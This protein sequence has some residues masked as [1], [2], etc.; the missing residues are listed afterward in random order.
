MD[1]RAA[2]LGCALALAAA[3][4]AGD[5]KAQGAGG[6]PSKPVRLI[7][8]QDPGS[9]ADVSARAITPALS[10]ALGQQVVLD[11]RPGAGGALGVR[12]AAAAAPD[13]Y[14]LIA[15][16][17]IAMILPYVLK[18]PGY[19]AFRDFVPIGRYTLSHNVLV[20]PAAL[21]AN[22]VKE[23][24]AL[25]KSKPG[26]LNLGTAGIGSISHLSGALFN[27]LAG[28]DAVVVPYKGGG[29]AITALIANET[30]YYVAPIAAVLGQIKTGRVKALAVGGDTRAIQLPDVPTIAEAGIPAYRNFSWAGL[31]APAG[32][33]APVVGRLMEKLAAIMAL[34]AVREQLLKTGSEP[35]L[36]LGAEFGRFMREDFER[37]GIAARSAKL[38]PE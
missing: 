26:Q 13:G 16:S 35:S 3:V 15:M 38:Q 17:S 5:A 14:A 12:A 32:T 36:L 20:V 34:P 37:T 11:Y 19:D 31:L 24:V 21:P 33:P 30:Q 10:E 18:D 9:A 6:Y 4:S 7:I 1:T 25:A 28:I 29:A 23:L 2:A 8:H 27:A 22:S